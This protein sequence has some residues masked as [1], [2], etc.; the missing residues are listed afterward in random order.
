ML[1]NLVGFF[2]LFFFIIII[3]TMCFWVVLLPV[4]QQ[5]ISRIIVRAI[6]K[7]LLSSG[8]SH[9]ARGAPEGCISAKPSALAIYLWALQR[10]TY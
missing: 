3:F 8:L 6:I 10:D 9:G 5:N 7:Q 4:T 2:L 1:L